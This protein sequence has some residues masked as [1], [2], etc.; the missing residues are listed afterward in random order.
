[1][2]EAPSI[3]SNERDPIARESVAGR[4]AA[5]GMDS[6]AFGSAATAAMRWLV[7]RWRLEGVDPAVPMSN[8]GDT[9]NQGESRE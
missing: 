9:D 7:E 8:I 2:R 1:M 3:W 6:A 5:A 4:R